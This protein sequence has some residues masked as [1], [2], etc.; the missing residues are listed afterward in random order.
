M[1]AWPNTLPQLVMTSGY[2]EAYPWAV[3]RTEMDAGPAKVRRRS[4]A[5]PR[6]ITAQI[7]CSSAQLADFESF[8]AT[9]LAGGALAF[10]WVEPRT[11]SAASF[12]LREAPGYVPSAGGQ[13][14]TITLPL[15]LLPS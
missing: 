2:Q 7:R 11:Q 10:T 1:P 6:P 8:V 5:A 15:E 14:W 3:L 9:D 13:W 12:R 4:T